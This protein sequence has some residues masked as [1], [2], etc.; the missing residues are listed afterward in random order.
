MKDYQKYALL[1]A[2]R[3]EID[4]YLEYGQM[5]QMA[6]DDIDNIVAVIEAVYELGFKKEAKAI[7][8]EIKELI[9]KS[10]CDRDEKKNAL[11]ELKSADLGPK[12]LKKTTL[13]KSVSC[14]PKHNNEDIIRAFIDDHLEDFVGFDPYKDESG[15]D[16]RS[17][18]EVVEEYMNSL[19]EAEKEQLAIDIKANEINM[20]CKDRKVVNTT[21]MMVYSA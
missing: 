12:K 3:A 13:A 7:R 8:K 18:M 15:Y 17:A 9:K 4:Q 5:G 20:V 11:E 2:V 16:Y 19:K 6:I 10:D 21:P 1:E 14:K